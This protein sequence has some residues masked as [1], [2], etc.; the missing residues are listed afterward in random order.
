M[1]DFELGADPSLDD[2]SDIA[3]G[4]RKVRFGPS[5][6]ARVSRAKKSLDKAASGS[7]AV[8]GVN[9]GFGDLASTSI[10]KKSIRD[11]QRNLVLSHAAGVG[12]PLGEA[13]SRAIVFLRANELARGFSGCRPLLIETLLKMVNRGVIPVIPSRGS[14]GASGDLAPQAHAAL[15]VI[16]AGRARYRGK[17]LSGACAMAA[18]GIQPLDLDAKE[19]LSLINGTQAMQSVGGLSL[20][21]AYRL[22]DAA[23]LAGAMSLEAI[24]G[25]PVPF[26]ARISKVK[27]HSGQ[28]RVAAKLRELLRKS[29]IRDAHREDDDRVQDPYS[30]RCIPQVHGAVA[31]LLEFSKKT[32]ETEMT[33]VTDNPLLFGE[34]MLSGGNFH[35]Q[36]LSFAYDG[37]SMALTALSG[38]SERR[39]FQV[40]SKGGPGLPAF[41]AKNPGLE[42]GFMIP[43]VTAAALA[44]ENKTLAHPASA[45]SIPTSANKEDFVS[46][47]MWSA[48]KM[49]RIVEN[50]AYVVAIE[51]LAAAQG[52]EYHRPLKPGLGVGQGYARVRAK[53]SKT[54]RDEIFSEKI[55][56]LQCAILDGFFGGIR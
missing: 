26:D 32:V 52:L 31:D 11:L 30:L 23:N 45:D 18:A 38:I 56:A 55:E 41:L 27:P 48:L 29:E 35:G 37:A 24:Q 19:G 9:T 16:G 47:G 50:C 13:Q 12:E 5:A 14:V 34:E 51:L 49:D 1:K 4:R 44:S 42:S 21:R 22:L 53:A 2:L 43:Q 10:P 54:L 33:S 6:R 28:V 36:A 25:T 3:Q 39:I 40:I 8:Y 17:N 15:P 20:V 7:A 46:M